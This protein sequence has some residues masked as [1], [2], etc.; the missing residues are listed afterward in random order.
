MFSNIIIRSGLYEFLEYANPFC[1]FYINTLGVE[2]YGLSILFM[3]ENMMGIKDVNLFD[4]SILQAKSYSTEMTEKV[5]SI[6]ETKYEMVIKVND[7]EEKKSLDGYKV[8]L[9]WE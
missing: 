2:Q 1:N 7:K 3:L 9:S 6:E 5:D 8:K 4:N